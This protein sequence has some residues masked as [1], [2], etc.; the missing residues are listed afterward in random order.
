MTYAAWPKEVSRWRFSTEEGHS[1]DES[2]R[3]RTRLAVITANDGLFGRVRDCFAT[4]NEGISCERFSPAGSLSPLFNRSEYAAALYDCGAY[5]DARHP[6]FAWRASQSAELRRPLVVLGR[7]NERADIQAA[8][9]AGATDIVICPFGAEE[10]CARTQRVLERSRAAQSSERTLER[11]GYIL[12]KA[13]QSAIYDG[14]QIRLTRYEF[15]MAWVLFSNVGKCVSRKQI[16]YS[17]WGC[18]D[19]IA[20]RTVEQ[21]AYRLRQKLELDEA[22]RVCLRTVYGRGYQLEA[23]REPC[24][25]DGGVEKMPPSPRQCEC[26]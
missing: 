5:F 25:R 13:A 2:E 15:L 26:G 6:L 11:A 9:E 18:S 14:K 3:E 22:S 19:D 1:P 4:G 7:F 12:D 21:H 8:F 10:L 24:N 17:V 20:R 16:A 23:K